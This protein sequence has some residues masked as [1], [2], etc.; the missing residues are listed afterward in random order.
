MAQHYRRQ[1]GKL[2]EAL[3]EETEAQREPP[4]VCRRLQLL[5]RME[6][7]SKTTNKFS[8]ELRARAGRWFSAPRPDIRR[9]GRR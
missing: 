8:P 6:H 7:M 5:R 3:R 4:R 1:V 2:C 9:A